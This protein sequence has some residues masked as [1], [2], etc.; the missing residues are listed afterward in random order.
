MGCS[1]SAAPPR[2]AAQSQVTP[3]YVTIQPD[4]SVSRTAQ[5]A[6]LRQATLDEH[7]DVMAEILAIPPGR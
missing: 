7:A 1:R 6:E 3:D 4:V 2:L 5:P